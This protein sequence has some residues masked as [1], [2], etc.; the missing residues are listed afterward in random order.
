MKKIV[1]LLLTSIAF[2][3]GFGQSET[4]FDSV[5]KSLDHKLAN[6]DARLSTGDSQLQQIKKRGDSA[7][8]NPAAASFSRSLNYAKAHPEILYAHS[9]L[10]NQ[11]TEGKTV[12][13]IIGSILLLALLYFAYK[14]F[15]TTALCKDDSYDTKDQ[16]KIAQRRPYSY[17]KV[18]LFWW[19][20]IILSCYILFYA[21]TGYL[22]PLNSTTILL[23]GT[24]VAVS[25]FGKIIDSE[26]I[27]VN[28][29]L[30]PSRHQDL[31][32]TQGF[33]TDILSD[34][35]GFSIHRFQAVAFNII[36]GV[37]FVSAFFENLAGCRYPFVE[38]EQWQF[39]LLGISATAYLGLKSKENSDSTRPE[40]A[41]EAVSKSEAMRVSAAAAD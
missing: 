25:V 12:T 32:D 17:G 39:T 19:T 33:F 35:T 31:N 24:G 10:S 38:F 9:I 20:M 40:R 26:Q 13:M 2:A 15:R 28:N 8:Q 21:L 14:L 4:K 18:Q 30:V 16:L 29:S 27:K 37:G 41:A 34:E 3:R 5:A 1:F 11:T 7:T 23:L 22:L 36:F 6:I